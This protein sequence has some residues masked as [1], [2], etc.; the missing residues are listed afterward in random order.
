MAPSYSFPK[1]LVR[2]IFLIIIILLFLTTHSQVSS[3]MTL[4]AQ[5]SERIDGFERYLMV[6]TSRKNHAESI[7]R[8][9]GRDDI[10]SRRQVLR[11]FARLPIV[12]GATSLLTLMAQGGW[13][14]QNAEAAASETSDVTRTRQEDSGGDRRIC[15]SQCTNARRNENEVLRNNKR[16]ND[17]ETCLKGCARNQC[18]TN[19]PVEY[20]REPLIVPS[21]SI[22]GLYSRWQDE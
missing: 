1:G 11:S 6:G 15:R 9:D 14:V 22:P 2:E 5:R 8:T 16:G 19:L 4:T 10:E 20:A 7:D 13:T 3:L 18:Q 17:Y 21:K 12:V